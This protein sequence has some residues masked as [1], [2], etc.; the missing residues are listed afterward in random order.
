MGIGYWSIFW[1]W[2]CYIGEISP[3]GMYIFRL[4]YTYLLA[5]G[6]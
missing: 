5:V 6:D 3:A 4:I 1:N 2:S